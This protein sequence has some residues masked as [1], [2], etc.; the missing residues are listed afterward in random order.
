M[1]PAT[2]RKMRKVRSVFISDLHLGY[3]GADIRALNDFLRSHDFDHL[4]LVGDVVDGWKMETRW[5]WNQEYSDLLDHLFDLRRRK[6]RVVVITGNHDERLRDMLAILFRPI[7]LRRY[8]FRVDERTIHR[9]ADGRRYVVMHG[10]QFDGAVIRGTS[11]LADRFWAW[12][13]E[14]ALVRPRP[15]ITVEHGRRTRWSLGKAIAKNTLALV[16]RYDA[17]ALNRAAEDGMDGIV[18]GHSHV[19]T[20]ADRDG[21]VLANCGSWTEAR[22][23]SEHHTA[24]VET[25]DGELEMV[26]WSPMRRGPEHESMRCLPPQRPGTRNRDA[27]TLVRLIHALWS[28][29]KTARPLSIGATVPATQE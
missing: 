6:V 21:V 3:K 4:Y 27:A 11:K 13:V 9:A 5:Y 28:P 16:A 22:G 15:E 7:L 10:D 12:L 25:V 20:L 19:P 24:V 29:P 14:R 17:N 18:C 1:S 26:K 8:G 2:P 23:S